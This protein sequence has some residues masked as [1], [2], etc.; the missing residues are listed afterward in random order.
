MQSTSIEHAGGWRTVLLTGRE[1]A[2]TY[3]VGSGTFGST[4]IEPLT[5]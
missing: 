1:E 2:Q 5:G 4:P 3:D